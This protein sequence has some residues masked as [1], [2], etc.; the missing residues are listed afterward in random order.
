MGYERAEDI[1][2]TLYSEA[3]LTIKSG[4]LWFNF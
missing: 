4:L 1:K 2:I 3:G